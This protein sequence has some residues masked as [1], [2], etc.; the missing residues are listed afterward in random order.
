[1]GDRILYRGQG[2]RSLPL[3]A[4]AGYYTVDTAEP[5]AG[6]AG[7]VQAVILDFPDLGRAVAEGNRLR[8]LRPELSLLLVTD[9]REVGADPLVRLQGWGQTRVL[10]WRP[11]YPEQ[12]LESL[13]SLV[14]PEYPARKN[15]V[16]IILPL[17]NEA[18][19]FQNVANF[20][21]KLQR[22]IDTAFL[23]ASIYFVN[24]GSKD[25]TP[26]LLKVI[27]AR[28][29]QS[30]EVV[31]KSAFFTV[32]SLEKN[33]RKAGTFIEGIATIQ[34]DVLV[35]VDAD[36]SF[37][38]DD[39][40]RMVNLIRDGYW[41]L[42]VGTKDETAEDRPLVRRMMSWAKRRLTRHLLPQ[43]VYDSQTGL[44]AMTQT[45]AR[46]ILPF[47]HV[48]AGLAVDLEILYLAKKLRFRALQLPV[49]CIDR[50]GS[51]VDLVKDSINFLK[52]IVRIPQLHKK[53]VF[54]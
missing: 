18:S 12:L 7:D 52:Q 15:D 21:E 46:K 4:L 45:A 13:Q 27:A 47:L 49:A 36:D 17:Y 16:A 38:V 39:I 29:N 43:G 48:E 31:Q 19:R 1:M 33:T 37:L 9:Y 11:E 2:A 32:A 20:V 14:H 25:E 28:L 6:A 50:D 30:M 35:F 42:V 54:P 24:D 34:A 41:D 40:G 23:N 44:K 53:A 3:A 22:F 8:A 10:P 26:E 5:E 51:H